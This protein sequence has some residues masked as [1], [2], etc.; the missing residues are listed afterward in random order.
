MTSNSL[1]TL[2]RFWSLL[3]PDQGEIR[4][5]YVYAFFYSLVNLSLPVGVQAIINLIQGGQISTSWVV[6]VIFVIL[7][8]IISGVLQINQLRIT[9]NLQ[10]KIF[11][12]A[13]FE[14]AYR[15]PKVKLE[16]IYR[17]YAPE[18]MNRFFD[19][20]SVQKG[21]SKILID[22]STA[23]IQTVFGL[24]LLSMYH[25]FFIVFSLVLVVLIYSIFKLTAKR[26]L[27]T[28]LEESKRKYNVAHWLQELARTSISF[29]LA[30]IT[31]LPMKRTNDWTDAYIKSRDS[32][33]RILIQQYV[34]MIIFKVLV[35]AGLLV[36]G[37]IL[38]M[39]Q[40]MNIGQFVAAEIIIL[41]VLNSVEKL[42]YNLETIYD[43]LTSLEKIGQVTDLDLEVDEGI[44]ITESL[45][46]EGLSVEM[47]NLS[48]TYPEQK[49]KI[50]ENLS[51]NINANERI[52]V[53]GDG[54]S[55]KTTL[56]YILAGM[57]P[58]SDGNLIFNSLPYGNLNPNH[59]RSVIGDCMMTEL[60]F[61]GTIMEN[62]T[63]GRERATF[64]NVQWAV[65][66]LGLKEFIKSLPQGFNTEVHS[67]GK[68][69]SKSIVDR[70]I[71]A[72]SI[73]DKPRLLL[74]RDAFPSFTQIENMKIF[75]FLTS[76]DRPWT[77]VIA[78]RDAQLRPLMDRSFTIDKGML[79]QIA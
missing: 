70:L 45:K 62:I 66:N 65:E 76:E 43:V 2:K 13:A 74:I 42:I 12:R 58:C 19:V 27:E 47:K 37:S 53:L 3:K 48:F 40:S 4:N 46:N 61:E 72:R 25:P 59:L 39:D 60:L 52:L 11:A 44:D 18:L 23:A 33:F 8:I 26:G 10:Q 64:E 69:F 63:M 9:E 28:S 35:A 36:V 5:I 1:K 22:F 7:G 50:F 6:L 16:A 32:H 68:L 54:D 38:V 78:S 55:G 21:L 73:V 34:L 29:K 20:V 49:H 77:L 51:L 71:L 24:L 57:Y 56:L 75:E 41:L 67:Q 14:F 31:E 15:I 79:N 30:G 17:H